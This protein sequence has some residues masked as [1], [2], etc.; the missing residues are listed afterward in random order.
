M[1]IPT[2]FRFVAKLM[3]RLDYDLGK[4]TQVSIYTKVDS[5]HVTEAGGVERYHS[6]EK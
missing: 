3:K 5:Y 6:D 2:F 1:D 4:I